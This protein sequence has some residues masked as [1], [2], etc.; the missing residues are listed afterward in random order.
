MSAYSGPATGGANVT[1]YG[2][3]FIGVTNVTFGDV[4]ATEINTINDTT[5]IAKTPAWTGGSSPVE[6]KVF[7]NAGV[8]A[9]PDYYTFS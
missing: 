6:V 4:S 8:A 3:N 9:R 5:I 2:Q 1:I 7:T